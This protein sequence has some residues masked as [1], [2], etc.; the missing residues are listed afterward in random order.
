[1]IMV[2]RKMINN[3]NKIKRNKNNAEKHTRRGKRGKQKL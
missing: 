2:V 1:M 3:T